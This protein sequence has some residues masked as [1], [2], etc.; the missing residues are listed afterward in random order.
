ML[1]SDVAT[2]NGKT[3]AVID[4]GVNADS[5]ALRR[6]LRQQLSFVDDEPADDENG[7]GTAVAAVALAI[8]PDAFVVSLKVLNRNGVGSLYDVLRALKWVG[9]HTAD[10]DVVNLSLGSSRCGGSDE[11]PSCLAVVELQRRGLLIAAA[12]GNEG[13]D[14]GTL[15]C[16]GASSGALAVAAIDR[17]GRPT[18]WSSRGPS[19]DPVNPKPNAAA[20]GERLLVLGRVVSGTSFSTPQAAGLF[21]ALSEYE[22]ATLKT[23]ADVERLTQIGLDAC[24]PAASRNRDAVGVG[25]LN[26]YRAT[27]GRRGVRWVPI[28]AVPAFRRLALAAATVALIAATWRFGFGHVNTVQPSPKPQHLLGRVHELPEGRLLFDDGTGT[29]P[30]TWA[31]PDWTRPAPGSVVVLR[32]HLTVP[33]GSRRSSGAVLEGLSR[34]QLATRPPGR[35]PSLMTRSLLRK[36]SSRHP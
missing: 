11:C 3:I 15:S 18:R 36:V 33:G 32:A 2:G 25:V 12:A 9:D 27:V 6:Q 34:F 7:H 8:A 35:D 28:S 13:P 16:P 30:L 21:A 4:T 31:G 5:P 17:Q 10:V 1:P 24:T 20:Q 23:A 14:R 29:L 19:A 26:L 22:D